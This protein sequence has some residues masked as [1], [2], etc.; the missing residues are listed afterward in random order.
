MAMALAPSV[1]VRE[2]WTTVAD[3]ALW[4]G[5]SPELRK[6]L[7]KELGDE[8][9]TN[10]MLLGGIADDDYRAAAER[11]VPPISPLHKSALNILFNGVKVKLGVPTMILHSLASPP[12]LPGG[13][14]AESTTTAVRWRSCS[15]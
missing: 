14:T 1:E 6:S 3:A 12:S 8:N 15:P 13:S 4:A 10:L 11:I 5:V 2:A 7:A 9:L